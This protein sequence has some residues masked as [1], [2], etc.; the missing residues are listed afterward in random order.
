MLRTLSKKRKEKARAGVTE[1][2][3]SLKKMKTGFAHQK[4][5]L[6]P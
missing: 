1:I 4:K 2:L 5:K 6:K 3:G